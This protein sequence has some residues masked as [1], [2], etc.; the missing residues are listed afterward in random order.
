MTFLSSITILQKSHL[1]VSLVNTKKGHMGD[2]KGA[3]VFVKG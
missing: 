3:M 2:S 1:N